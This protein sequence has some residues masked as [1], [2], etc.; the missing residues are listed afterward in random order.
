MVIALLLLTLMQTLPQGPIPN[1]IDEPPDPKDMIEID[2]SKEPQRIPEWS[3]WRSAFRSL[4]DTVATK[5]DLPT[6]VALIATPGDLRLIV[7]AAEESFRNDAAYEELAVALYFKLLA[8]RQAC[9]AKEATRQKRKDCFIR[10]GNPISRPYMEVEEFAYRQRTLD[11][12]DRL[13][14]QLGERGR[15]EV[16]LALMAWVESQKKG[17]KAFI[18]KSSLADY[19]KPR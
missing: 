1:L 7:R 2:G 6:A 19:Y 5:E 13:L 11:I 17:M 12:R 15:M 9:D 16:G 18:H 4:K 10:E 3:A 8:V 14:R